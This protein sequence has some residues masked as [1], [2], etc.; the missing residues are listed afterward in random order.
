MNRTG[1]VIPEIYCPFPSSTFDDIP[2][3]AAANAAREIY[4]LI[5]ELDGGTS[6]L[7]DAA[8]EVRLGD[9]TGRVHPDATPQGLSLMMTCHLVFFGHEA[10]IDQS[11]DR[12]DQ[13]ST[14]KLNEIYDRALEVYDGD[15]ATSTDTLIA[16]L[17][18]HFG[19]AVRAS[20]RP[21]YSG[22]IRVATEGY[23]RTQVWELDA[24][25]RREMP[26]LTIYQAM[27]RDTSAAVLDFVLFPLIYDLKIPAGLLD[28]PVVRQLQAMHSNYLAWANDLLSL[29][30]EMKENG[31]L[32]L[33]FVLQKERGLSLQQAITAAAEM[34]RK[35]AMAYLDL[36]DR[37]PRLGITLTGG[38]AG[39]LDQEERYQ[40]RAIA[41]QQRA[42]RFSVTS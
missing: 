41:Y 12:S 36:K 15:S 33:V 39:L 27:R 23:L 24:R 30:K 28:H 8:E 34:V 42:P 6:L 21:E 7:R 17:L 14:L 29:E 37:L 5:D 20:N 13:R 31:A 1:L 10:W 9:F 18:E 11:H 38:L 25:N 16:H 2:H 22:Q 40:A 35:E 26:P 32:N 19:T 4:A 3:P